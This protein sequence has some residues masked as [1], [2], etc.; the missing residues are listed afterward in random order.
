[1]LS[2][3]KEKERDG[4]APRINQGQMASPVLKKTIE[5]NLR[6]TALPQIMDRH[7]MRMTEARFSNWRETMKIIVDLKNGRLPEEASE[8]RYPSY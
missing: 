3:E 8:I 7:S 5:M 1:M 2:A 4:S 6:Y